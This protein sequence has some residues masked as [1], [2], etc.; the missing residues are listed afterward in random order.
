MTTPPRQPETPEAVAA[1]ALALLRPDRPEAAAQVQALTG[2]RPAKPSVVVVGE[3]KRGKSS[4]VNALLNLPGLSPVDTHVATRSYL[5][6]NYGSIGRAFAT[7]PGAGAPIP[8]EPA[9]LRN[10]ATDRGVLPDGQAPP[11]VIDVECPSPLLTNLSLIDTPGVGGLDS[12]HGEIAMHAVRTATA[13]LFVVD[14][15]APFTSHELTFLRRAS[16]AID[17]VLFA[18]TKVDAYRGWRQVVEDDRALL[19]QHAPRFADAEMLPVSSRMFEQALTAP[20]PELAAMLRTESRVTA[21]QVALQ[22][23]VAAKAGALHDAN[24]LRAARTSLAAYFRDL[25]VA[26]AAV[27]PDPHKVQALRSDRERLVASRR[28][29]GRQWQLKLRAEIARARLDSMH[30][31]LAEVR[32]GMHHWRT[33]IDAADGERLK[34]VPGEVDAALHASSLRVFDR[35]V[36]RLRTVTQNTLRDMFSADEIDE[37]YADIARSPAFQG[38]IAPPDARPATVEDKILLFGGVAGGMGASRLVAYLPA[39]LG[40]GAASVVLAPLS[41]GLG[42]AATAWMVRSRRHIAEKNHLKQWASEVMAEARASLEAEVGNQFIDAEHT[43]TLALDSAVQRRIDQLDTEIKDIDAALRLDASEKETRRKELAG[44]QAAVR[45][46][47]GRI[48]AVLPGLRS[49]GSPSG[50]SGM[51]ASP[52]AA[53]GS[54]TTGASR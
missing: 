8:L 34:A 46:A 26:I 23:K 50:A 10:W 22:A 36:E 28:S 24:V 13:V 35:I 49:G 1:A 38:T 53:S 4:L 39:A 25:G 37:V 21:L 19:R 7:V 51:F 47:V 9:D 17:L 32:E 6:F 12:A 30:D 14:A 43:L 45:Q 5:T 41:I 3:T 31:V 54:T 27:D 33:T 16:E 18:I 11:R 52:V 42:L 29:E 20:T 40:A 48:D 15:S 44:T 2:A